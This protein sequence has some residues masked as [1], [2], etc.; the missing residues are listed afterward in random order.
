M[1]SWEI[2]TKHHEPKYSAS[3]PRY[4]NKQLIGLHS[5][6]RLKAASLVRMSPSRRLAKLIEPISLRATLTLSI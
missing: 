4:A 1:S 3:K 2:T 5:G 6:K